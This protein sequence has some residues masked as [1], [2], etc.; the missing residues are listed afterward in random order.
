MSSFLSSDEAKFEREVEQKLALLRERRNAGISKEARAWLALVPSW[1]DRLAEACGFPKGNKDLKV[2]LDEARRAALCTES[3][4]ISLNGEKSYSFWMPDSVRVE[5]LNELRKDGRQF[6][7]RTAAEIGRV[8]LRVRDN[9]VA[10]TPTV[11]YWAELAVVADRSMST[12]AKQLIDK[13]SELVESDERDTGTATIWLD[14][15]K[16][17]A[18]ALGGSLESAVRVGRHRIELAYRL[19]QDE[20]HL[21]HFLPR[22]EQIDA[23]NDLLDNKD[24]V[25]ALHYMGM[26]GVGKTMLLRHITAHLAQERKAPSSRIDF[27]Y[28][29]PDYPVRRPGQLLLE[30]AAEFKSYINTEKLESIFNDFQARTIA[31]HESLSEETPSDNPLDSIRNP[32]FED[33]LDA[34]SDFLR[35]LPGPVL[36]ILDT[37]EELAKAQLSGGK[38]STIEATFEILERLHKSVPSL[39]VI[40]AG[41]RLLARSGAGWRLARAAQAADKKHLPAEKDY[42]R[43]HEIRGFDEAE[44]DRYLADIQ[45]LKLKPDLRDAILQRSRDIGAVAEIIWTPPQQKIVD[46]RYNPFDL[47]LY[48]EWVKEDPS[49]TVALITS[50]KVDPY[51]EMRIIQRLKNESLKSSLPAITLLRRFDKEMLLPAFTV[52][53]N[54][55]E[56]I[57][58][59]LSDQEWIDHQRD[60]A[61][62]T[63]FLEV[64]RNLYGRLHSYYDQPSLRATLNKARE[65]LGPSLVYLVSERQLSKL[66]IDHIEAALRLAPIEQAAILWD[67]ISRRIASEANWNWARHVTSRLLGEEGAV[68]NTEHPLR[69]SVLATFA[70][71]TFHES[72]DT[73]LS[74]VWDEVY[75]TARIY[76]EPEVHYWLQDRAKLKQLSAFN[77]DEHG[78]RDDRRK[79][80]RSWVEEMG[81]I[82]TLIIDTF[83]NAKDEIRQYRR[84]QIVASFCATLEAVLERSDP[85]LVWDIKT[86]D[87]INIQ[88]PERLL[89]IGAPHKLV[90][91]ANV[92][93]G[94]A[95]ARKGRWREA[96]QLLDAA[97][98]LAADVDSD[99]LPLQR[100]EDW[101]APASF[102][103][104]IRLEVLCTIPPKVRALSQDKL[105]TWQQEAL[106]EL[107]NI[108]GERLA[109]CLLLLSLARAPVPESSLA[110]LRQAERYNPERQPL[111]VVHRTVPPLFASLALGWLAL[112]N[113]DEA[114]SYLAERTNAAV[115]SRKDPGT[116]KAAETAELKVIR[117]MRIHGRG[118]DLINRL[119]R[120]DDA[121]DILCSRELF[122]VNSSINPDALQPLQ[123]NMPPSMIHAWWRSQITLLQKTAKTAVDRMRTLGHKFTNNSVADERDLIKY[124]TVLNMDWQEAS[125]IANKFNFAPL[126]NPSDFVLS[127]IDWWGGHPTRT[128]EAIRLML[129]LEVL[130]GKSEL[131]KWMVDNVGARLVAELALEEGELLNLRLP[132]L[133][134]VLL[135]KAYNLFVEAKDLIGALIAM[136]LCTIAEIHAGNKVQAERR[137]YKVIRP[138]YEQLIKTD[139]TFNLPGWTTLI[140][141]SKDPTEEKLNVLKHPSWGGWMQRLLRCLV[142]LS[143]PKGKGHATVTL[144]QWL[145]KTYGQRVPIELALTRAEIGASGN[146]L[147]IVP[148]ARSAWRKIWPLFGCTV[149]GMLMLII[150]VFSGC[151]KPFLFIIAVYLAVGGLKWLRDQK[152]IPIA[153]SLPTII[154][155]IVTAFVFLV[156]LVIEPAVDPRLYPPPIPTPI[157]GQSYPLRI[158]LYGLIP[159]LGLVL[160]LM[161]RWLLHKPVNSWL[162][163]H[164]RVS[165][166]IQTTT[167][168]AIK[169][170]ETSIPL[171]VTIKLQKLPLVLSWLRPFPRPGVLQEVEDSWQIASL[172]SYDKVAVDVPLRLVEEFSRV[173]EALGQRRLPVEIRVE[174]SLAYFPWE[175]AITLALP[176]TKGDKK[177][178]FQ[179]YRSDKP[180]IL[181]PEPWMSNK[182]DVIVS[183]TWGSLAE[184]GWSAL[185]TSPSISNNLDSIDQIGHR[186]V[187]HLIG[188][189]VMTSAGLRLQLAGAGNLNSRSF[190]QSQGLSGAPG[191]VEDEL[192]LGT[193]SLPLSSTAVAIIQAEPIDDLTARTKTERTSVAYLRAY[194]A[195]VHAAGAQTVIMLPA[196]PPELADAVL[197]ELAK[198]LSKQTTYDLQKL[199]DSIVNMRDIIQYKDMSKSGSHPDTTQ[200][201]D[202]LTDAEISET[203]MEMAL[204]VSVFSYPP[205]KLTGKRKYDERIS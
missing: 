204:D 57:Y 30:L 167:G 91:Y 3:E 89:S 119:A 66:S 142:W 63:T 37:C 131:E 86:T 124:G 112:G 94:R 50:G 117:R 105:D 60:E 79:A 195:D 189:P 93:V 170:L 59:E 104:R 22:Q 70:A 52:S 202:E 115:A 36:L 85:E 99:A 15:G 82:L 25:W 158:A 103:E 18:T 58:R 133:A 88:L 173:S 71:A 64:N 134:V 126:S 40:F 28:L 56:E 150:F 120:S 12:T 165:L 95:L 128:E 151:L 197:Y 10:V 24:G 29:S 1:T 92:L 78:S 171:S 97:E 116:V 132:A 175:A 121:Y 182:V 125:V 84:D 2:F 61:L 62:Q 39:R 35:L 19:E 90:V 157:S 203:R 136:Q 138:I 53:A 113:A 80:F 181:G 73:D 74:S 77:L 191:A 186:K 194:A 110:A 75:R 200:I 14:A 183:P 174:Q 153:I 42:L 32:A 16:S 155:A 47:S 55:F 190:S 180:S 65:K 118:T 123:D 98:D 109:S 156:N 68:S 168:N 38:L 23:F 44:A 5:T 163:S 13:V 159:V 160:L 198:G 27:D 185:D 199:L 51:V 187:L 129:R 20:R 145:A 101:Y 87:V 166:Q 111:S 184:H 67:D 106:S 41:R 107:E 140:A 149:V 154:I 130:G 205:I 49:L 4:T 9:G 43:L 192:L 178:R 122:A 108:D 114:L 7:Y 193:D 139:P 146:A 34:F 31:L 76:P 161:L 72:R 162:A 144:H 169:E 143:E 96:F 147:M 100:W 33:M 127:A 69:A 48:A 148:F 54:E 45:K 152:R 179:F 188:R 176:R 17:L 164:A 137:I 141:I 6:I 135:D 8:I 26:G 196:L 102:K 201:N 172:Y 46:D 177:H 21:K 81:V 83:A 11:S